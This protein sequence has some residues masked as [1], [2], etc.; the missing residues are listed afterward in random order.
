MYDHVLEEMADAIAKELRVDSNAV[1]SILSRYW[2]DKIAHVWQ[3]DDML[4]SAHRA[5]KP[6]TRTDATR[7]L[8]NVFDHHDSSLGISWASLDVALEDYDFS[9]KTWPEEKYG[10]VHGIFKVWRRGDLAA[11]QF[12]TC[13]K[14]MDGNLPDALALAKTMAKETQGVS[15][16]VGLET[17]VDEDAVPWLTVIQPEGDA[18]P[19]IK[20]SGELCTQ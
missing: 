18:G 1:L 3:V 6:I 7:L 15:V 4:E 16:F 20:E 2:Q 13:P 5:G 9:L 19:I 11:H 8:Y 14:K 17:D 12:G 10:E